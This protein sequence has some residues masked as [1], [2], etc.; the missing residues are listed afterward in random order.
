MT[1]NDLRN[2]IN[3]LNYDL[4]IK[5]AVSSYRAGPSSIVVLDPLRNDAANPNIAQNYFVILRN[6]HYET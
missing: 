1:A 2:L 3:F 6:G 5:T 4:R